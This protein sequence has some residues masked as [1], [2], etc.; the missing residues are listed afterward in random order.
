[1]KWFGFQDPQ[2]GISDFSWCLSTDENKCDILPM[3]SA[4]TSLHVKETG[5]NLP[6]NTKLLIYVI[7]RNNAGLNTSAYSQQFIIDD[8]APVILKRV[9]VVTSASLAPNT[10]FDRSYI[11]IEWEMIDRETLMSTYSVSVQAHHD[12]ISPL[13]DLVVGDVKKITI[14]LAVTKQLKDGNIYNVQVSM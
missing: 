6:L 14:P 11:S 12:G 7:A 2:S 13:T 3:K 8:S 10:Q 5:L 4:H 9:K 1:M